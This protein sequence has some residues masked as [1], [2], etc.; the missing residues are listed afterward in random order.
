MAKTAGNVFELQR[1]AP[2]WAQRGSTSGDRDDDEFASEAKL[3]DCF[4]RRLVERDAGDD[5]LDF[6]GLVVAL[7]FNDLSRGDNVFEIKDERL[8]SSGSAAAWVETA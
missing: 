4:G 7:T 1:R 3:D 6:A 8:S 5:A 2:H